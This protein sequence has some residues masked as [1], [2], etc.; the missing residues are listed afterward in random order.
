M[1][2][3]LDQL[4]RS[5]KDKKSSES[6]FRRP[7]FWKGGSAGLADQ[8]Y[9][10]MVERVAACP[11]KNDLREGETN[12]RTEGLRYKLM[13]VGTQADFYLKLFAKRILRQI[14]IIGI[15]CSPHI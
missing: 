14:K 11:K 2:C 1:D 3:H 9:A 5:L 12:E 8:A 13:L 15:S 10:S 6:G 4:S 7:M